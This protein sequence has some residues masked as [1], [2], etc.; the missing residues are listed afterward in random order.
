VNAV[1]YNEESTVV[2]SA[3]LDGC[4]RAWDTKGQS[5]TQPIQ[6]RVCVF[7]YSSH[8]NYTQTMDEATDS[9]LSVCVSDH[10]ILTGS[11][12]NRVRR[13]DLRTGKMTVDFV[14]GSLCCLFIYL[15]IIYLASVTCVS[16]TRDSQ[17]TLV[18][19]MD[20]HVRLLDKDNGELLAQLVVFH[21]LEERDC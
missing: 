15:F 19:T 12:D 4:V 1:A 5:N 6:V 7:Q 18:S 10:E 17:C 21:Y 20:G 11:A 8:Y 9:V 14:G 3:C 2:F 16:F 13:Y